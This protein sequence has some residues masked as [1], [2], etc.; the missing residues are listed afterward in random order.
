MRGVGIEPTRLAS[1]DL[2][3][4]ALTTRPSSLGEG[5]LRH[6]QKQDSTRKHDLFLGVAV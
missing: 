1:A 6:P 4:A 5:A 2:K 3:P